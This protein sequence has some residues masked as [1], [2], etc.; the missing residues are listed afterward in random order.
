MF[1]GGKRS[2]HVTML[3]LLHPHWT[4][5]LSTR[6]QSHSLLHLLH[7][8]ANRTRSLTASGVLREAVVFSSC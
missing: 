6:R 3:A 2:Y 7:V 4:D 5:V 1:R 8:L